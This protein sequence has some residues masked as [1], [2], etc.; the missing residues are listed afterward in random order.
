M[1]SY[2]P[3]TDYK[4]YF[5]F[6]DFFF[7]YYYFATKDGCFL[8]TWTYSPFISVKNWTNNPFIFK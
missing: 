6:S 4:K 1:I 3:F 2:I 5:N 7:Y 8:K